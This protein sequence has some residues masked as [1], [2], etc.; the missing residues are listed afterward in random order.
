MTGLYE[1][2]YGVLAGDATLQSALGATA[3]NTKVHP[4][5]DIGRVVPPAVSLTVWSGSADV[6]LPI[7]RPVLDISIRS[8]VGVSEVVTIASRIE[9]LLNRKSFIGQGRVVH[10][11]RKEYDRDDFEPAVQEFTR[12]VRYALV[13]Q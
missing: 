2:F 1:L 10:L 7:E 4:V 9:A 11:C 8:K 6:G 5:E 12:D 13:A 3:S